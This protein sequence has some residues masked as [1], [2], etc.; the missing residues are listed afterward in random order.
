MKLWAN[1]DLPWNTCK[2][3]HRPDIPTDPWMVLGMETCSSIA[4]NQVIGGSLMLHGLCL[5]PLRN[6]D[7]QVVVWGMAPRNYNWPPKA[8]EGR[9]WII[10]NT[11]NPEKKRR[12]DG[13]RSVEW[14]WIKRPGVTCK[15]GAVVDNKGDVCR[16]SWSG[17]FLD[18]VDRPTPQPAD[19]RRRIGLCSACRT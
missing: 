18:E 17:S 8:I 4:S 12:L 7:A 14:R 2:Q 1:Q 16:I 9:R 15:N 11:L 3:S 10:P 13:F 19:S 5:E 6:E